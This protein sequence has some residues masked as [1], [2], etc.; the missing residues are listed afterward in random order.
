MGSVK[1]ALLLS[2]LASG[3]PGSGRAS[4][5]VSPM[6]HHLRILAGQRG[7]STILLRNNGQRALTLKLYLT[8]SRFGMDGR[9]EDVPPGTVER[10][11]APWIGLGAE[12]LELQP[13]EMRQI[14][15][16]LVVPEDARGSFWT[17][18]YVEEM[19]APEATR[20]EEGGRSYQVFMRQ[21][22]GV[23]IFES[24]PGTEEPG[25]V[26]SRVRVEAKGSGDRTLT[27]SVQN[28]GNSLLQCHGRIEVRNSRGEVVETLKPGTDG[29]F[30]VF[31][32]A[33]REL[34]VRSSL[35]LSADS[36]T[37]LAVVD[38]GGEDL[39]AGE[40]AFQVGKPAGTR[41]RSPVADQKARGRTGSK[42]RP[43]P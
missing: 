11:C 6:E 2:M 39:V 34:P 36:Y 41:D 12:L 19:S 16:E 8:D 40:E 26:V 32:G 25:A 42:T 15:V 3:L 27:V 38:Y 22:M 35:S 23:R 28:T 9:E 1:C 20:Q 18:L 13:G 17:K 29:E 33:G 24:V 21:R 4:F 7:G 31:P 5:V 37:V 14:T 10:S 30:F 43:R